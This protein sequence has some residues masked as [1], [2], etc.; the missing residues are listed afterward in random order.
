MQ[1]FHSMSMVLSLIP[2]FLFPY[3]I[4]AGPLS[5]VSLLPGIAE[6]V[7]PCAQSCV[8]SL[9]A[10]N[11]PACRQQQNIN[12][13]CTNNSISGLTIGEEALSCLAST[14]PSDI[15]NA[16]AIPVYEV[17]QGV[18]GF[19]PMTHSIIT[20]TQSSFT[21]VIAD[22]HVQTTLLNETSST[23]ALPS[24]ISTQSPITTS[25]ASVNNATTSTTCTSLFTSSSTSISSVDVPPIIPKTTTS[26]TASA[27]V[28]SSPSS[29]LFTAS[30]AS[31]SATP[32][33][34]HV[35]TKP[36]IAG[37]TVAGAGAAAIS[38]GILFFI[39]CRR[40]RHNSN[41]RNSGSSFGG[42]EIIESQQGSPNIPTVVASNLE[43]GYRSRNLPMNNSSQTY[44]ASAASNESRWST[45]P[46]GVESEGTRAAL[47]PAYG[48]PHTS[49]T[50][51][52][53]NSQL[54]PDKPSYSLYPSPLRIKPPI[55][56]LLPVAGSAGIGQRTR[57]PLTKPSPRGR[58]S[59]DTSQVHLQH[60][61]F[62]EQF[63]PTDPFI[64]PQSHSS[65]SSNAKQI[66][67][68]SPSQLPPPNALNRAPWNR[69]VETIRKPVPARQSLSATKSQPLSDRSQLGLGIGTSAD[70]SRS[71]GL[72]SSEVLPSSGIPPPRFA[73]RKKSNRRRP[74]THFSMDSDT[75]FEDAG[76]NDEIPG[77]HQVLSP[78]KERSPS[79]QVRYPRIPGSEYPV[80]Q[81]QTSLGS[82]TRRPRRPR[83]Q[84]ELNPLRDKS[85]PRPPVPLDNPASLHAKRRGDQKASELAQELRDHE[86]GEDELRQTAKWKI[87]VS[88]GL[89]GIK[90][91]GTPT[92]FGSPRTARSGDWNGQ[93]WRREA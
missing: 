67:K 6:V 59:S 65:T 45:W 40:R 78:V 14:C 56:P 18:P 49:T 88:P 22:S 80:A 72:A 16:A 20:A 17:C 93:P 9:I 69:S 8:K 60:G 39:F 77:H 71:L 53:T 62:N 76:D 46:S 54:L 11:F 81:H 68:F 89:E 79:G 29:T 5:T 57:T 7:P 90:D 37:V 10:Q 41:K 38:F 42:G 74:P 58:N 75:S 44:A 70:S 35:L 84:V 33:A 27:S 91:A 13:L 43:D 83:V 24:S 85:L 47:N 73:P 64:D 31:S 34:N 66:G 50:T 63:S 51:R 52:R 23:S 19:Q 28:P 92:T 55:S 3:T 86:V 2:Y 87:L 36:Q 12:C 61:R 32:A 48:S 15:F 4:R 82:P 26:I 21:S 1:F 25:S 30:S